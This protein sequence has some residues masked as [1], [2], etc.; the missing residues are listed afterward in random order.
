M[1]SNFLAMSFCGV[2]ACIPGSNDPYGETLHSILSLVRA[3][4]LSIALC[5]KKFQG[6]WDFAVPCTTNDGKNLGES[7]NLMDVEFVGSNIK[8][9]RSWSQDRFVSVVGS[10]VALQFLSGNTAGPWKPWMVGVGGLL[11]RRHH[12]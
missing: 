8:Q 3:K 5:L 12:K 11:T 2:R 1:C 7:D 6:T 10:F 9:L 4:Y